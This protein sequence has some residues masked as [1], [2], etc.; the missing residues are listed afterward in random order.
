GGSEL[1][2]DEPGHRNRALAHQRDDVAAPVGELEQSPPLFD[3]EPD[4]EHVHAL[5]ERCD[6]V[7][8]TPPPHLAEQR[9]LRL[10]Q[11]LRLERKQVTK[12]RDTAKLWCRRW[13]SGGEETSGPRPHLYGVPAK[14]R[15]QPLISWG[16]ERQFSSS[17]SSS[18]SASAS[19]EKSTASPSS[20]T[21]CMPSSRSSLAGASASVSSSSSSPAKTL[22]SRASRLS[23]A[24]GRNSTSRLRRIGKL[25]LPAK[26]GSWCVSRTM[27]LTV[28]PPT[29]VMP[30]WY[31]LPPR[32]NLISRRARL[33][34]REPG[35]TP[36]ECSTTM[37]SSSPF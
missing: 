25:G 35:F 7:A 3:A 23:F 5:D 31:R 36:H 16:I 11:D 33:A 14:S 28:F 4:V 17:S 12:T 22:E 19:S 8:V 34:S 9:L 10:A 29:D 24:Y 20:S 1:A 27:S 21:A 6:D 32:M 30:A 13:I 37:L 18:P 15:R 2:R 26:C